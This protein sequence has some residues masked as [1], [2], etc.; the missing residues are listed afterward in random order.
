MNIF[1]A[2][3]T[4]TRRAL[5]PALWLTILFGLLASLQLT[6]APE[7]K[8]TTALTI[9]QE[10]PTLVHVDVGSE[11]GSHGDMLAF[12]AEVTTDGG[13]K[14]VLSGLLTTVSI[15]VRNG[16][17]F[18]DRIANMVFYLGGGN[19]LVVGG[20]AVYP[21]NEGVEMGAEMNIN[22]PQLRAILGGTGTFIGARGQIY[23]TRNEDGTYEH[24]VQLVEV[25]SKPLPHRHVRRSARTILP[26]LHRRLNRSPLGV[27]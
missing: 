12:T 11:G 4:H 27:R 20:K 13:I 9:T 17:I 7:M 25:A 6:A 15:P 18:Q 22:L 1:L 14:G 19:T 21:H 5:H 10:L 2:A 8:V 16:E 3:T 24:R 26:H 23:T